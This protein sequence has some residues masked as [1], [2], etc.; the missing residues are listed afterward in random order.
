MNIKRLKRHQVLSLREQGMENKDIAMQL[1][2]S[3]SAVSY[4]LYL[5]RRDGAIPRFS[6][7]SHIRN[8]H[9]YESL[10]AWGSSITI[11]GRCR[12]CL[13]LFLE[14]L[15]VDQV[16]EKMQITRSST[17]AYKCTLKKIGLL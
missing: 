13:L 10:D 1:G 17:I 16:A 8:R 7:H 15:S 14:G 9:R 6:A 2:M 5:A 4:A 3:V 12:E 11:R